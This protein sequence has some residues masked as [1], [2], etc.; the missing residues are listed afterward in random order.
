MTRP[1]FSIVI[2]TYA[3][4]D[5]LSRC[6]EAL[7]R[8]EYPPSLLDV[9]VMDDGSPVPAAPALDRFRGRI[10]LTP[11]RQANA[12]PAAAR[13]AA[14]R[15]ATGEYIAFTDDDCLPAPDWLAGFER[16]FRRQPEALLGGRTENVLTTNIY[17]RTSQDLVDY[18]Y[19]YYRADAGEAP[20]FTSNNMA[21]SRA[22]FLAAGAFDTSFPLAAGEDREF[23]MRW[24]G[25]GRKLIFVPEAVVGHAHPLGFRS[26]VR[27]HTNY[28]RG[29]RHLSTVLKAGPV[30]HRLEPIGFYLGMMRQ[31]F[32][33][34]AVPGM[35][36]AALLVLSQAAMV[37]GYGREL[38]APD[39]AP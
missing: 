30:K 16:A 4:P 7:T 12:G 9:V 26:F 35:L 22:A 13:N 18:L 6:I 34:G 39:R 19:A 17:A 33:N 28:G 37:W 25:Q 8:L 29:A 1:S 2:P 23:G 32:V 36:G 31:P 38:A 15:A 3:R 27:Q 11:L 20:F 24:R 5:R 21:V 10:R 14:A